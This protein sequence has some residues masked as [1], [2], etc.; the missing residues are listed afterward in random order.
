MKN[1][2][3]DWKRIGRS[4]PTV[5]GRAIDPIALEQCAKNYNKE[6]FTALIWPEHYRWANMG[7]VEQLKAMRNTEG[8]VDLFA[9]I[10]PNDFYISSN[11]AGQKLFT[12]ME[13]MP[14]FRDTGEYYLTGLAATDSPAS[15][16]TSEMRFSTGAQ[17]NAVF[18]Q[19]TE[20]T[21]APQE[22]VP[23]WFSKFF[24]KFNSPKDS[25]DDPMTKE[26]LAALAEKLSAFETKL[27][28]VLKLANSAETIIKPAVD[29][30]KTKDEYAALAAKVEALTAEISALKASQEPKQEPDP[31]PAALSVEKLSAEL[32]AL[33][34]AFT[35][36]LGE[37]NGTHA[38]EHTGHQKD[39]D[40]CL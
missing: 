9:I 34:E 1:L 38:G 19:F 25:E 17:P 16:A 28:T 40:A 29:P 8:G 27:D 4:G 33:Q 30:D 22:S 2:K 35:K 7:T 13:L 15:A 37:T 18:T 39:I 6:L 21:D 5:D 10:A 11:S 31:K 12:S 20:H 3:T 24:E 36:A 23:G 32:A 14:N 26:A